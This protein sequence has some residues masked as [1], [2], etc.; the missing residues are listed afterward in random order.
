MFGRSHRCTDLLVRVGIVAPHL[1]DQDLTG[2]APGVLAK[3]TTVHI[4]LPDGAQL[5]LAGA[6]RLMVWTE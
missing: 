2:G 5:N 3:P 4:A 1:A 6:I